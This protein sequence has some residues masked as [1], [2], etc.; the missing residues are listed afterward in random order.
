MKMN[1][2]EKNKVLLTEISRVL[3]RA[4]SSR[5]APDVGGSKSQSN[6]AASACGKE[7]KP[8]TPSSFV[9]FPP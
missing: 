3:Q 6:C 4:P 1:L 7:G 2:M 9:D 8:V 5:T